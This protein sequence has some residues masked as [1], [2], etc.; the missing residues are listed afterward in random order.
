MAESGT[1]ISQQTLLTDPEVAM[2][3][4]KAKATETVV[5]DEPTSV[6]PGSQEAIKYTPLTFS[7]LFIGLALS[8]FLA[9]LD[10]TILAVAIP[11]IIT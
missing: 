7:L 11:S 10:Q 3:L 2:D 4:S 9:A 6:K 8:V 1:E 5:E